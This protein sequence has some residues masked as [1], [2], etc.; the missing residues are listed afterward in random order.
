MWYIDAVAR[1]PATPP[2]KTNQKQRQGGAKRRA[3]HLTHCSKSVP[4][5][6]LSERGFHLATHLGCKK[7]SQEHIGKLTHWFSWPT[8]HGIQHALKA[9]RS[10]AVRWCDNRDTTEDASRAL[11]SRVD[12]APRCPRQRLPILSPPLS[13]HNKSIAIMI[14]NDQ[15]G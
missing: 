11:A 12:T 4:H 6:A 2:S 14:S 3:N 7:T 13:D 15:Q 1:A 5:L 9:I 10:R 8:H